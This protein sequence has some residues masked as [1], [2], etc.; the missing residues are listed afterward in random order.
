LV[1]AGKAFSVQLLIVKKSSEL[2]HSAFEVNG[3][4]VGFTDE[5]L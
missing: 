4:S 2:G 5:R 3:R 1:L